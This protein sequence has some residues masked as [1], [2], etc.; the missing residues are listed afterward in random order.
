MHEYSIVSSLIDI[1]EREIEKNSCKR[2]LKLKV[3]IGKLSGV[4]PKLI[5]ESFKVFKDGT[6]CSSAL[7]EI[8]IKEIELF[9]LNCSYS[10]MPENHTYICPKCESIDIKIVNG[11]ELHLMSIEME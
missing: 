9:C 5:E 4:E 6:C 2:A 7:M 3:A 1:C 11:E 10:F 8:E